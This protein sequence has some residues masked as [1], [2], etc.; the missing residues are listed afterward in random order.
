MGLPRCQEHLCSMRRKT[1]GYI[2]ERL[3]CKPLNPCLALCAPSRASC[4]GPLPRK[5]MGWFPGKSPLIDQRSIWLK[6]KLP[7]LDGLHLE[8]N[9][10]AMPASLAQAGGFCDWCG[11]GNACCRLAQRRAE[12]VRPNRKT[13]HLPR[14][15][16]SWSLT[17]HLMG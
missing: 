11:A 8:T 9:L 10:W 12:Q 3:G 4:G 2:V 15:L 1:A 13:C 17:K 7:S 5:K 16:E 14:H 6:G